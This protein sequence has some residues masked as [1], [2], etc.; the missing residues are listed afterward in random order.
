MPSVNSTF[1]SSYF[2]CQK[3]STSLNAIGYEVFHWP[4][5]VKANTCKIQNGSN[6]QLFSLLWTHFTL[7]SLDIQHG[8]VKLIRLN[9]KND[10]RFDSFN[11]SFQLAVNTR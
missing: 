4:L 6:F 1:W 11:S 7:G 9:H 8:R 5:F 3:L 10:V 2:L